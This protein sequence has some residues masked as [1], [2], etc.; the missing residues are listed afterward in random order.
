MT[1][2]LFRST[3]LQDNH[4]QDCFSDLATMMSL[5]VLACCW[6]QAS[7]ISGNA[8]NVALNAS[9]H[10]IIILHLMKVQEFAA[11][12]LLEGRRMTW[13]KRAP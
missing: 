3:E 6:R 11:L 2:S 8:I 4:T 13:L 9:L 5:P 1:N 12:C 7:I 10:L